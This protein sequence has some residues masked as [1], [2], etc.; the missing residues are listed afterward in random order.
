MMKNGLGEPQSLQQQ[1]L[2]KPHYD[3]AVIITGW[4]APYVVLT[5]WEN[6]NYYDNFLKAKPNARQTLPVPLRTYTI[7][8]PTKN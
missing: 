1:T 2:P 8:L 3:S 4:N 7:P 5:T 6:Q